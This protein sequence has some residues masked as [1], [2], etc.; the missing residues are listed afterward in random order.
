MTVIEIGM[1]IWRCQMQMHRN[2]LASKSQKIVKSSYFFT[3]NWPAPLLTAPRPPKETIPSKLSSNHF[4]CKSCKPQYKQQQQHNNNDLI[5]M[6]PFPL[7]FGPSV[8]SNSRRSI[9][10]ALFLLTVADLSFHFWLCFTFLC[11][12]LSFVHTQLFHYITGGAQWNIL[13]VTH[14]S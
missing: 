10:S 3:R 9:S 5:E 6:S 8:R 1:A 7:G 12:V 4:W 14:C 13:L 11:L 2:L